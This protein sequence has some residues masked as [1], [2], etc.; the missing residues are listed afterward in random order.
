MP[1]IDSF[2]TKRG[3]AR[4]T[5]DAL[6]FEESVTGYL[7]SLYRGYWR[8]G[9]W[10]RKAIFAGYVFALLFGVGWA[11][12]AVR[13]GRVVLVAGVLGV[14]AVLWLVDYVRGYR[15]PDRVPLDSVE[16]VSATRGRKGLTRP[17]LVVTYADGGTTRKRRV[18]LPSLYLADG[19]SAFSRAREAFEERGFDVE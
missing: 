19:E 16:G 3:V 17:R 18:N 1:A 11:V 10:W 4:F 9:R 15:S 5:D 8:R 6:R 2:A 13:R 7:R 14:L 12:D